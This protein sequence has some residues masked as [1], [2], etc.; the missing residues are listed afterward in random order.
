M[1]WYVVSVM[2]RR[3]MSSDVPSPQSTWKS[4]LAD[5]LNLNAVFAGILTVTVNFSLP[6]LVGSTS[7]PHATLPDQYDSNPVEYCEVPG[8][9]SVAK[10]LPVKIFCIILFAGAPEIFENNSG[11]T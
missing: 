6:K 2:V 10:P 7:G 4:P 3:K 8:G 5:I 9:H 1:C 11:G